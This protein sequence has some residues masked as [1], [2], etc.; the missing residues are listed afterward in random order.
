MKANSNI[1][2]DIVEDVINRCPVCHIAMVDL[3]GLP[4]VLPFNFC[5][6]NGIMYIHGSSAGKKTQIWELNPNVCV[7]FSTDYQ[8]YAQSPNIACSHSMRYKS[9]LLHGKIAQIEDI[10]E[11]R[12]VLNL[13]MKKYTQRENFTY[14]LASLKNVAVYKITPN[15]IEGKTY[16][17]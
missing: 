4:Y 1:S 17:Y 10:E 12:T 8:M 15:K 7:A 16:G 5:Y 9:V 2:P 14:G 11:K 3:E 13:V 6:N